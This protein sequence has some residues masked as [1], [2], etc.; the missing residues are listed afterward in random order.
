M[1]QRPVIERTRAGL[2]YVLPGLK[3]GNIVRPVKYSR[4]GAQFVIPGTEQLPMR[5][6]LKIRMMKW[7]VAR[8]GQQPMHSTPLFRPKT[9]P[10]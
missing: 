5:E 2:Q 3:R 10:I 8:R 7:I 4:E 9:Y 1:N 6:L